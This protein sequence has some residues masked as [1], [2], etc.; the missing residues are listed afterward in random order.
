MVI[1][2]HREKLICF[3]GHKMKIYFLLS[4]EFTTDLTLSNYEL[5]Y[6]L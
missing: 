4:M 5:E 6:I 2:W 3:N 1:V